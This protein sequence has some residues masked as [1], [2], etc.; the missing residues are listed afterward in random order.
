[1][2]EDGRWV[3]EG[4]NDNAI[5][6]LIRSS[7]EAVGVFGYSYFDQNRAAVA[8]IAIDGAEAGIETIADGRYPLARSLYFYVNGA[9]ARRGV[10]RYVLE[11]MS[12]PA[13][14]PAGYLGEKGLV[15]LPEAE[16]RAERDK[17]RAFAG[18]AAEQPS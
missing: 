3:D 11:F 4:E 5:I 12:E 15:P 16:R 18:R 13:L 7:A 8:E 17:A 9:K 2:R 10:A 1:M 14:G 6:Q